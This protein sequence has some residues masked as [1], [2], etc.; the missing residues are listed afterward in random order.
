MRI[1]I[2]LLCASLFMALTGCYSET[3]PIEKKMTMPAKKEFYGPSNPNYTM[4]VT[5]D[6]QSHTVSGTMSVQFENNLDH[7]LDHIY[8]NLWPNA[9]FFK[10][11][12]INV[13]RVRFN[14]KN[15]QYKVKG[16]VLDISGIQFKKD[17]QATVAMDFNVT[18]RKASTASA[19]T[20]QGSCSETGFL[21]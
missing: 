19:G 11:G 12:G 1:F 21:S 8:F 17:E 13:D 4:D 15:A 5:Y 2:I 10:E 20:G 9:K 18:V 7:T 16:T 3:K 14:D 6:S